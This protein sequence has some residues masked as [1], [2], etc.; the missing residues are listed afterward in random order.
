MVSF[1]MV[2]PSHLGSNPRL[3]VGIAYLWLIILSVVRDVP[4]NSE[5]LF[6]QLHESQDQ[7]SSVIWRY[8]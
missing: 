7:A 6:D 5:A 2:E 1:L 4:V 3:G 8:S